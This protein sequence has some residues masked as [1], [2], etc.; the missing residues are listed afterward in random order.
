MDEAADLDPDLWESVV[1]P[2]LADRDG[3]A[4]F[5]GTPKG[6]NLLS[7]LYFGAEGKPDWYRGLFTVR[8]TEA[9]P[10][11]EI[12]ALEADLPQSTFAR[13]FLCDF[14][15][16]VDNILLSVYDVENATKRA[17]KPG[18]Y[19][20]AAKLIGVDVARQGDDSSVLVR[21]QGQM[22]WEPKAW[23]LPNA[24]D[25]ADRVAHEINE[26]EPDAVFVDGTG[27]YGA[28]V[29]DRLR[30]LGHKVIEV[31]FAGSP[32]SPKFLNKRAEMWWEMAEWVK[33]IGNLPNCARLK[34]DLCTP[35]YGPNRQDKIVL[36]SKEDIKKRGLPSPDYADALATT[37][38][39]KVIPRTLHDAFMW[40]REVSRKPFNPLGRV[41]GYR[42]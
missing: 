20:F 35:T 2:Q 12:A 11:A 18:D 31:Q 14:N 10:I 4:I 15:A 22:L 37:F 33:T 25:V 42:S 38:A 6:T 16:A 24:M 40:D 36:E 23:K 34:Q 5:M 3:W 19:D 21:R 32:N 1:R 8:Q 17:A 27:G 7:N 41:S 13:E 9:L 26:W 28:G 39:Q 29:I 30:Q